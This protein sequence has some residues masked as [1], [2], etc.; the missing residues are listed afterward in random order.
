MPVVNCPIDIPEGWEFVRYGVPISGETFLNE[1]G[2]PVSSDVGCVYPLVVIRRARPAIEVG[3]WVTA[4][5]DGS[6]FYGVRGVIQKSRTDGD[7]L[8]QFGSRGAGWFCGDELIKQTRTVEPYTIDLLMVEAAKRGR[9][10]QIG[11]KSTLIESV[12]IDGVTLSCPSIGFVSYVEATRQL[13]WSG[14]E[15]FGV[16]R[17]ED[18]E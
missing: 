18:A 16:E 10:V 8:V 17:W 4:S 6:T 9:H 2:D 11:S 14:G 1:D 12:H 5:K 3:D 13:T 15:V 7:Y